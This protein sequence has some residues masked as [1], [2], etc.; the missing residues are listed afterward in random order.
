MDQRLSAG[1]QGIDVWELDDEVVSMSGHSTVLN[2]MRVGPVYT[3]P[4]LRGHGYATSLVHDQSRR[5]IQAG[6]NHCLLYT[7]LDNPTSNAIYRRIGYHQVAESRVY[8]F[9]AE[10]T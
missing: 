1:D 6:R 3:P 4:E 8:R 7:D 9:E 10:K 5:S 2:S